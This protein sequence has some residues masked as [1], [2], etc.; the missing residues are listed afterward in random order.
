MAAVRERQA[1]RADRFVPGRAWSVPAFELRGGEEL[2]SLEE[3]RHIRR[4]QKEHAREAVI[5]QSRP[6]LAEAPRPTDFRGHAVGGDAHR[7]DTYV[8][9]SH[10]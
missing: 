2:L 10:L 7:G 9:V 4:E 5:A 8:P 3:E 6:S 1:D